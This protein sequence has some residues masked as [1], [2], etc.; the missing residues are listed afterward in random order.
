MEVMS[1]S[2]QLLCFNESLNVVINN[3]IHVMKL[4]WKR[5]TERCVNSLAFVCLKNKI[6]TE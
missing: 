6:N 2:A 4:F 5:T 3:S 1:Q